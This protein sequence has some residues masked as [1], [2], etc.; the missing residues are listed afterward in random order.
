MNEAMLQ[1]ASLQKL[2]KLL[3]LPASGHEQ[4]WEME[5]ADASRVGEFLKTYETV[6]LTP[7]DKVALM[8]LI[9]ASVDRSLSMR[10]SAPEEW[11]QIAVLLN[12]DHALHEETTSY[13]A[14]LETSDSDGW[15]SLTPL[16][17]AL[18]SSAK[19]EMARD[20]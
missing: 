17:R 14:C 11:V 19:K 13:W 18:M 15:F 16:V 5:L 3:A 7:D 8:A 4:D 2:E 9:L 1:K 6:P 10:G 12:R 20:R